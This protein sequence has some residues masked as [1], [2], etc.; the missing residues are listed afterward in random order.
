M[1]IQ[2]VLT[3]S[4]LLTNIG[5][6]DG[7]EVVQL[8]ISDPAASVTRAV[9]ELKNFKKVFLRSEQREANFICCHNG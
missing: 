4:V 7:E 8:Y 3:V 5:K 2:I 6:Y 1:V 9:R